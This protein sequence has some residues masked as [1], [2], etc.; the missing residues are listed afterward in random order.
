MDAEIAVPPAIVARLAS[1]GVTVS[2]NPQVLVSS[3]YRETLTG[4]ALAA[5]TAHIPPGPSRPAQVAQATHHILD[6]LAQAFEALRLSLAAALHQGLVAVLIFS[7]AAILAA[8]FV[9]DT[10]LQAQDTAARSRT[11]SVRA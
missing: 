6:M 9:R 7:I 5:A 1:V 4:R 3:T 11:P 8:L 2:I 10:P